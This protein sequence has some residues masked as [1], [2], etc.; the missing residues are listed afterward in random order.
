MDEVGES[1]ETYGTL[2]T[3]V[4]RVRFQRELSR[5]L[6]YGRPGRGAF[7]GGI[8]RFSGGAEILD[9]RE[10]VSPATPGWPD[11]RATPVVLSGGTLGVGVVG[12]GRVVS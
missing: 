6:C 4:R 5:S 11:D 12:L 8:G 2:Y 7:V 1:V 10:I 9:E 3:N